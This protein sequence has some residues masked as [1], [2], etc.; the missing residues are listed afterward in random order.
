[1]ITKVV[2]LFK[3]EPYP[4]TPEEWKNNEKQSS[5]SFT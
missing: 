2:N 1:M 3:Q 5:G 4:S